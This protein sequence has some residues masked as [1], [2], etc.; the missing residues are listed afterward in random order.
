MILQEKN[1]IIYTAKH[2]GIVCDYN[3]RN[4]VMSHLFPRRGNDLYY[5]RLINNHFRE[6]KL[7][8]NVLYNTEMPYLLFTNERIPKNGTEYNTII[9]HYAEINIENF[10][11]IAKSKQCH[12]KFFV[13]YL[14]NEQY[15]C[16]NMDTLETYQYTGRLKYRVVRMLYEDINNIAK[17]KL[18]DE[19]L[20]MRKSLQRINNFQ[21]VDVAGYL[22]EENRDYYL[23]DV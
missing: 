13:I 16:C 3:C 9:E 5:E 8:D 23:K 12:D 1:F 14:G 15:M 22:V 20:K 10:A 18:E 21:L 17:L 6:L 4:F 2:H 7:I 11:E 19:A